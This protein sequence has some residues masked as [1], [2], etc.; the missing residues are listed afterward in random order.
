[1]LE[2]TVV[3]AVVTVV[4]LV[5][6]IA[7]YS[8]SFNS[9]ELTLPPG[10]LPSTRSPL[11]LYFALF[12]SPS[13]SVALKTVKPHYFNTEKFVVYD[14]NYKHERIVSAKK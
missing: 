9:F 14:A 6:N 13:R 11:P 1:M 5:E 12:P 3:V 2:S 10:I 4:E 7:S 8:R